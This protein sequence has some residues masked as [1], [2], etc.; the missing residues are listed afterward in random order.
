MNA[1]WKGVSHENLNEKKMKKKEKTRHRINTCPKM[2]A[3]RKGICNSGGGFPIFEGEGGS[4]KG[5]V[6]DEF[7]ALHNKLQKVFQYER[8]SRKKIEKNE[9]PISFASK[10]CTQSHSGR[11][12]ESPV[13]HIETDFLEK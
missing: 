6:Q 1:L 12:S 9:H 2:E 7:L 4:I 10:T 5:L 8:R 11:G 13:F 3:H